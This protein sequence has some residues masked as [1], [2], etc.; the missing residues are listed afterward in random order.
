VIENTSSGI[1]DTSEINTGQ[2]PNTKMATEVSC[3]TL[4]F[5]QHKVRKAPKRPR[6]QFLQDRLSTIVMF[7]HCTVKLLIILAP[8]DGEKIVNKHSMLQSMIPKNHTQTSAPSK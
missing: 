8:G 4:F 7:P 1:K 3:A 5:T 6:R 2:S